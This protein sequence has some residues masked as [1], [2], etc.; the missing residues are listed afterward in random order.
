MDTRS[1]SSNVVSTV[2][3]RV[4][5]LALAGGMVTAVAGAVLHGLVNAI[6][7]ARSG[8]WET[9]SF[10]VGAGLG[11]GGLVSLLVGT[12]AFGFSG[13]LVPYPSGLAVFSSLCRQ[14]LL[15]MA[16]GSLLGLISGT[17]LGAILNLDT[18]IYAY[19]TALL[20]ML[21]GLVWGV[22]RGTRQARKS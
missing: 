16:I 2:L 7:A 8:D 1:Q 3:K 10:Y 22:A 9:I 12:I 4:F 13:A 14:T 20:L 5:G 21:G 19:Y 11:V 15:G 6:L 18:F 17:S